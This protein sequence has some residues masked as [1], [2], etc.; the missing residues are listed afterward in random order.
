M[1]AAARS[2]AAVGEVGELGAV[3]VVAPV[4]DAGAVLVADRHPPRRDAAVAAVIDTA[5]SARGWSIGVVD[6]R[7]GGLA[8]T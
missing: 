5:I 1:S 8:G 4:P 6:V 2:A 3:E 7:V